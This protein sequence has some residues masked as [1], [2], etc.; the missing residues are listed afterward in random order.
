MSGAA[1]AKP[2]F[3]QQGEA[4]DEVRVGAALDSF[5]RE[6]GV[7]TALHLESCVHCGLCADACH[8]YLTTGDPKYTPIRKL[9]PRPRARRARPIPTG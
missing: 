8:F 3:D 2:G 5:V 7:T 6:F 1:P 4:S 9:E